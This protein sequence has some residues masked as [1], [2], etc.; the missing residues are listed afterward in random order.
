MLQGFR[1]VGVIDE[2]QAPV[3]LTDP[4]HAARHAGQPF[5]RGE[6]AGR[7][8]LT[9]LRC[10]GETRRD[11]G[12]LNLEAADQRQAHVIVL[13]CVGERQALRETLRPGLD[14][15]DEV[16]AAPR[17]ADGVAGGVGH[18]DDALGIGAVRVD[19]GR[20]ALR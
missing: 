5:E 3:R 1:L 16:A 2:A 14:E 18:A 13:A 12:V 15:A 20:T 6:D 11:Q 19:D 8:G 10:Q 17:G 9:R 4:L 7:I